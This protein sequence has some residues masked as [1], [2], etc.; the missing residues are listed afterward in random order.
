[1]LTKVKES[2]AEI[3]SRLSE[4]DREQFDFASWYSN[5]CY[6][7]YVYEKVTGIPVTDDTYAMKLEAWREAFLSDP[8]FRSSEEGEG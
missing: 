3:L 6:L 1:M 8:N 4:L 5:E 7:Y 2:K